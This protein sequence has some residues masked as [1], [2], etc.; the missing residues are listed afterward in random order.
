MNEAPL[1]PTQAILAGPHTYVVAIVDDLDAVRRSAT[2]L[3]D[4]KD[5]IDSAVRDTDSPFGDFPEKSDY[6]LLDLRMAG[7]DG[8]GVLRAIGQG[9]AARTPDEAKATDPE[10]L[11][12]VAELTRRQVQ[13]LRGIV[14]GKLNKIIAYDLGLSVRTVETYRAQLL[15]K[16]GVRTTAGAVRLAMAAGL[17]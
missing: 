6:V 1:T 11:A 14:N 12:R 10:A 7:L 9:L 3:L 2:S 17:G 15:E 5:G 4:S 13:V 16:L 8:R